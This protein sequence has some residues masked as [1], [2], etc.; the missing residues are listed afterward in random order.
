MFILH[1]IPD[2]LKMYRELRAR[3]QP[4]EQWDVTFPELKAMCKGR[5]KESPGAETGNVILTLPQ[6]RLPTFCLPLFFHLETD[7]A[8]NK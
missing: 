1:F 5:F 2:P 7:D 3:L 8:R 6:D 4:R